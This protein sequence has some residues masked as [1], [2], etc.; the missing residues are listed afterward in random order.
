[1]VE[2]TD[3]SYIFATNPK[4]LAKFCL[5][6]ERFQYAYRWLTQWA[7]MNAYIMNLPGEVD[8]TIKMPS[9]T[10]QNGIDPWNILYHN[11]PLKVNKLEFLHT[12]VDNPGWRYQ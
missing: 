7:K 10:I 12:K 2:A 1:M 9:I 6:M 4:S 3:D 11:V 8:K 5:E